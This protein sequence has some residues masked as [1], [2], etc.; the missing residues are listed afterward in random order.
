LV[1]TWGQASTNGKALVDFKVG[2]EESEQMIRQFVSSN[3]GLVCAALA[4][5]LLDLSGV[6]CTEAVHNSID[7]R[8]KEY[9]PSQKEPQLFPDDKDVI[10]EGL[11]PANSSGVFLPSIDNRDEWRPLPQLYYTK[12]FAD[13]DFGVRSGVDFED[14]ARQLLRTVLGRGRK[15]DGFPMLP[16]F[17]TGLGRIIYE[18]FENTHLWATTDAYGVCLQRSIRGILARAQ[19]RESLSKNAGEQLQNYLKSTQGSDNY[20]EISVL[21]SGPGLVSR[22][23]KRTLPDELSIASELRELYG[24]LQKGASSSRKS[25][26]GYGLFNVIST[27]TELQG[28]L[29]IRTGRLCVFRDTVTFPVRP[30]I[31]ER[32]DDGMLRDWDSGLPAPSAYCEM[33]GA[34]FSILLPLD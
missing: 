23:L 6:N 11:L 22:R 9:R 21:D 32:F 31:A 19:N 30:E 18:L 25:R 12:K 8:L 33:R 34:A 4:P 15:Q 13:R 5:Q 27:L 10:A 29:R 26:R 2:T 3:T 1:V 20:L 28:F 24:C 14:T 7:H 17:T 16:T